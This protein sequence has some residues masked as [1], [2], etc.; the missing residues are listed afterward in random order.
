MSIQWYNSV[1][2]NIIRF[3]LRLPADLHE[4][5]KIAAVRDSRSLNGQIIF[6]LRQ[7]LGLK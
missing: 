2:E 5:V 4:A 7:S 6:L 1:M 3:V